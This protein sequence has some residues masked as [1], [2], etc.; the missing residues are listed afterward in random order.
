MECSCR[1]PNG[2]IH[3][4]SRASALTVASLPDPCSGRHHCQGNNDN[5]SR[6]RE[7]QRQVCTKVDH[8]VICWRLSGP[9]WQGTYAWKVQLR[10]LCRHRILSLWST[11]SRLDAYKDRRA[12]LSQPR[13]FSPLL[14]TCVPYLLLLQIA[15]ADRRLIRSPLL[16]GR[17][18][19]EWGEGEPGQS[20]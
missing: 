2:G 3:S 18:H 19:R 9:C 15:S 5:R 6:W 14:H 8:Q 17:L 1:S 4:T 7:Q 12:R 13:T 16:Q 10:A 11:E 20:G